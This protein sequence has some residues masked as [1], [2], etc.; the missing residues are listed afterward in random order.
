MSADRRDGS[1]EDARGGEAEDFPRKRSGSDR[2]FFPSFV[3][4]LVSE[5]HVSR[6]NCPVGLVDGE[7]LLLRDSMFAAS[8]FSGLDLI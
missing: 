2:R 7:V 6:K 8:F 4:R 3:P 5:F 1:G